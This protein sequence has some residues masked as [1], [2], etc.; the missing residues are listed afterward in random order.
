MRNVII[1]ITTILFTTCATQDEYTYDLVISNISLID[2]TGK[3][4]KI[5]SIGVKGGKIVNI[6]SSKL[7]SKIN[8]IDGTG[9]FLI[10]G[11]FDCHVHTTD[12]K[13]DFPQYIHYGVTSVFITGGSLCSNEYYDAMRKQGSQDSIPA[14]IVFHTSQH[15]TM[16]GRHPVKTYMGNWINE[17]TVFFLKDTLQIEK[18]VKEVASYPIAGIK[19]TIE[20]GPHPPFVERMPQTFINKVQKEAIKNGTTVF[21]HVS[22][23]IEVEMAIDA[24][25]QNFVHWTGIDIDFH[26]DSL[27]VSKIYEIRPSFITTLMIDKGFLYPLFPE[28]IEELRQEQVF[29]E[30]SLLLG[31]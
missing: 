17:N 4:A 5:A 18:L 10:P 22:D 27:L 15:F 31:Q 6:D 7:S 23:N 19:L 8:Q 25:I 29:E 24:G 13:K 26:R 9:K 1:L 20:D 14:P 21:A 28:W 11:L 12:F 2:G 30:E 3:P 16:E